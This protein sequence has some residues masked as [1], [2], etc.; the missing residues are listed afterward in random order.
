MLNGLKNVLDAILSGEIAARTKRLKG[1]QVRVS[2]S[3]TPVSDDQRLFCRA[4][5]TDNLTEN[6]SELAVTKGPRIDSVQLVVDL[7]LSLRSEIR[8][9]VLAFHEAD[10]LGKLNSTREQC[11]ELLVYRVDVLSD[12][13]EGSICAFG[14][15]IVIDK[16]ASTPL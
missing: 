10:F 5:R 7:T 9:V 11:N 13:L 8:S 15:E 16:S 14:H 4:S 1:S 12:I 2:S 3:R 6:R